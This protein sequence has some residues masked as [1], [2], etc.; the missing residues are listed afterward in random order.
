MEKNLRLVPLAILA[1]SAAALG[2]AYVADYGFGLR[3][4]SLCQYQ[5]VAYAVAGV[6][7]V[8][9]VALPVGGRAMTLVVA[10]CGAAFLAGAGIAFY[11]VGVEQHWWAQTAACAAAAA[12]DFG[13]LTVEALQNQ[14]SAPTVK[15]CDEV[16][17]TLFGI[18]LAGYN[19]GVSLLLAGACLGAARALWQFN[20]GPGSA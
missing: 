2:V 6:L 14:L 3:P 12:P 17:W 4:C 8:F 20:R 13:N 11:H 7:A 18:S 5:R 1:F 9:A 16:D 15:P 19:T 10:A